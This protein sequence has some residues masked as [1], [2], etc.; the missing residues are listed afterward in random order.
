VSCY[1]RAPIPKYGDSMDAAAAFE[2]SWSLANAGLQLSG[3]H[4]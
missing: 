3:K 2:A 4:S 1:S